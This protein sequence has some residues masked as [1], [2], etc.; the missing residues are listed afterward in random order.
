MF[1]F[2]TYQT[3]TLQR[4]LVVLRQPISPI[5]KG[6]VIQDDGT[7]RL[8]QNISNKLLFYTI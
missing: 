2:N 4:R 8:S 6:H 5:F 1:Q 7:N 3:C